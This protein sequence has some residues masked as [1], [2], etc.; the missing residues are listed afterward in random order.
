MQ[1]NEGEVRSISVEGLV[2]EVLNSRTPLFPTLAVYE[3]EASNENSPLINPEL[4]SQ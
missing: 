1:L 3:K 4:F 2:P